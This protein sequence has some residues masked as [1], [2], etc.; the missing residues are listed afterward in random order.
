[1]TVSTHLGLPDSVLAFVTELY[2]QSRCVVTCKGLTFRGFE[3]EAGIRQGCTLSPLI[4]AVVADLLLQRLAALLSGDVVRA[5]ADDTA[6]V[7]KD[8]WTVARPTRCLFEDILFWRFRD[9]I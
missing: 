8:W 6:A 3:I 9:C 7:I 1:M 4:F 2:N 5:F